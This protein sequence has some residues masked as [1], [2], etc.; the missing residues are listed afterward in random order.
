MRKCSLARAG[1]V[2]FV[3]AAAPSCYAAITSIVSFGDSLTD[4][5]RLGRFTDDILWIEELADRL[6]VP[7]PRPSNR[8]GTNFAASGA[9]TENITAAPD[10]DQQVANYLFLYDP[11]GQELVVLW[12]GHNDLFGGVEPSR[13]V[14]NL[15]ALITSIHASGGRQFLVPA[16]A[17]VDRVPREY[18]GPNEAA[19][20]ASVALTNSLLV[21][22]INR[23]RSSLADSTI[24]VPDSHGFILNMIADFEEFGPAGLYGYENV[25]DAALLT[26]GDVT[27]YM[28]LDPV[29]PTSKTHEFIGAYV[30]SFVP[31]PGSLLL[32]MLGAATL[33][34]Y[35][36][37]LQSHHLAVKRKPACQSV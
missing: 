34:F 13:I 18:G 24:Y 36:S 26:G 27:T 17:P 10:M 2:V 19:L 12:G 6:G 5:G 23:L 15:S 31:E 20:A 32:I 8:G 14:H 30:A 11:T 9:A 3:L 35:R 16:L 28:W 4:A 7:I 33:A 25:T 29:H 22:E 37:P 1:V 21:D